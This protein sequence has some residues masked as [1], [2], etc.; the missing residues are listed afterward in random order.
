VLRL[1]HTFA[2]VVALTLTLLAGARA[3]AATIV[4]IRPTGPSPE[5]TETVSRLHGELLSLGLDVAFVEPAGGPASRPPDPRA[6][7]EPISAAYNADAVIDVAGAPATAAVDIYVI[8]RRARRSEVSRIAL[9]SNAENAPARFAIRTIEFL[10]SSLV[11]IDL[12]ARART[13]SIELRAAAAAPAAETRA[14]PSPA[15]RLGVEAGAALLTGLDGVGPAF[16]PTVRVG[17]ARPSGLVLHAALAGLGSRPTLNGQTGSARVAQ[18]FALLGVGIGAPSTR[19]IRPYAALSAGVLRTAIDG[20][21]DAPSEPHAVTPWSFL[22]EGS[23][24]ARV[25]V[26]GRTFFTLAAHVQVAA[27]YVAVHIGETVVAT[28]GRPNFLLTL[29]VGAWL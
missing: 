12:A 8:D 18:Q 6:R 17:W 1:A 21:A 24:G 14:E 27:P 22:M 25:N 10:R 13:G 2:F 29:T 23:V 9:E 26:P 3:Q 5:L 4:I 15:D 19:R 20:Q 28:T 16:L 11:E 7:L